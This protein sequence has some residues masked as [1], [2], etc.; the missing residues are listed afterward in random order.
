MP[1]SRF[2]YARASMIRRVQSS[3]TRRCLPA[4][5]LWAGFFLLH[6]AFGVAYADAPAAF[7]SNETMRHYRAMDDPQLSPDGKHVL[8]HVAD[9]AADGGKGHLWLIEV[10]GG[11][12]R[13]LSYSP[14]AD[15]QGERDGKWMPDG[16]SVLFL[17]HRTEHTELFQLPM[18]GGEAQALIIKVTP[19]VD[20]S[21]DPDALPPRG[22]SSAS[23]SASATELELDVVGYAI[24]PDGKTIALSAH[25]PQ[26]AGEKQDADAKADARWVDHDRHGTRL[27]LFDLTTRRTALVPVPTDVSGFS[28]NQDGSELIVTTQPGNHRSDLGPASAS[29]QVKAADPQHPQRIGAVPATVQATVWSLDGRS[30]IYWAQARREAP[31]Y[32]LD[33]YRYDLA[34]RSAH[35]LTDG[36]MGS[37]GTA[38]PIA[39]EG[40]GIAQL[41]EAGLEIGLS[42]FDARGRDPID[43]PLATIRAVNTNA[44]RSGWIFLGSSSGA[45]PKLYYAARL[46][47]AARELATPAL[48]PEGARSA[49][50]QRIEWQSDGRRIEGLLWLPPAA[51]SHHIPLIVEVHGGPLGAYHDQYDPFVDFLVGQGWAV[52]RPNPRGSTGRGPAFAAAN[53]NDLGG[54]DY[55]DIMAG[56]DFVV[57]SAPVDASR[58]ALIGYSY[59]GEMAGFVEGKTS[60]FKAIVSGAPVIDQYSE[61][62]TEDE[63]WYDRWYFGKPWERAADAWRQSPLAGVRTA[64]TP[65]LLLQG[66]ADATDP[67]GQSEEMYRALRQA[68]VPVELVTY[69]RDDH[70]ALARA[71]YG[72]PSP[73]P[74]HGFDGRRRIVEFIRRAFRED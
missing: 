29:W 7:P 42:R 59:G 27:Y 47:D 45:P 23:S 51:R 32:Y 25:D 22:A 37:I 35:D 3:S 62:G 46:G 66:E 63:S 43:V 52:L 70:G 36:L 57:R 5:L 40:G 15:K 21:K 54:G 65:F 19:T 20:A 30:L 11:A 4:A 8:V 38:P 58:M 50:A 49:A 10:G 69:P 13:Q 64:R 48:A 12:P 34:D 67:P 16:A 6:V 31:P 44:A 61:Y 24:S 2:G 14:A 17:A 71:I 60:R 28:W 68:N 53:R 39:L 72:E 1:G 56:V 18:N 74:W 55:R 33:L 9:S 73:E 41:V 26:T